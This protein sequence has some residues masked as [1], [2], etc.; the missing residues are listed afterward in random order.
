ML[1]I[2]HRIVRE[3]RPSTGYA[4]R[5]RTVLS[6]ALLLCGGLRV[7]DAHAHNQ[8]CTA[9]R[10]ALV[11][12]GSFEN[13]VN[14][15]TT[16]LR[17]LFTSRSN[18]NRDIR[19]W[20]VKPPNNDDAGSIDWNWRFEATDGKRTVDL[21]GEFSTGAVRQEI[22]NLAIG[23]RYR[24]RFDLAGNPEGPPTVKRLRADV[25]GR[26]F[27]FYFDTTGKTPENMGWTTKSITFVY[28]GKDP[29]IT[30]TSREPNDGS[31]AWGPFLDN[32]RIACLS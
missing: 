27:Y 13:G 2:R 25:D 20:V 21:D 3:L 14:P 30:F 4:F 32:V 5:I 9:G 11:K 10:L 1:T 6:L 8:A 23:H 28:S 18:F 16:D 22:R 7:G 31:S 26:Q 24:I 19:Y 29:H 15:P 17:T 12:N